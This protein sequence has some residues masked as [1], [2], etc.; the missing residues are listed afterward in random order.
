M[1]RQNLAL[2]LVSAY[3]FASVW[4]YWKGLHY[5]DSVSY[6]SGGGRPGF[7]VLSIVS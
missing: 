4:T 5:P 3:K 1:N 2:I 6:L 7:E